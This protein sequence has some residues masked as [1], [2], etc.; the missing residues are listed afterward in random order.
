MDF[1]KITER[2]AAFPQ[3]H[4]TFYD[5]KGEVVSVAYP[6]VCADV[7]RA[8]ERLQG[9][10]IGAGMRVGIMASNCYEWVVYDLALMRLGCTSVAFPDDFG[11]KMGDELIEKYRLALLLISRRDQWAMIGPGK[12]TVY[13]DAENPPETSARLYP[14]TVDDEES[15]L[16]LTF[17]SG[18]SGKIKCLLADQRGAEETIA[19]FYRLFDFKHEDRFLVFLP[20]SSFQQRLMVYAGFYYGFDILL[21]NPPQV[22]TAFKDLK[23]T[24]CLAPPLLYET[25]HA[26]FK[27]TVR[28]LG[29]AKRIVLGSLVPLG[30]AIPLAPLRERLLGICYGKIYAALGGQ[31][32]LMW[33]GMAPI[34]RATLDFFAGMRLPLYE[35]YGLTE[36]GA[37]TTNTREHNRRGSVGRPVV[38]GSVYLAED[39]E[40]MVRLDHLQTTGYLEGDEGE[41]ARTYVAPG[42]IAT[43]DIGR[44]DSEGYLYLVGRK[45]EIIITAQGHKVHPESLEAQ[46]DRC[47]Q[48]EHAVVFGNGLSYLVA[49]IS[50]QEPRTAEAEAQVKRTIEKL[51]ADLPPVGRIRNFVITIE[52]FTRDNGLMTRNLKLDRRAIF[53][54]FEKELLGGHTRP[55]H[56]VEIA[57]NV[58]SQRSPPQ[59]TAAAAR[60]SQTQ[61]EIERTI[62]QTWQEVLL[63]E[64][65][66]VNDNF[67]D[68]GGNSLLMAQIQSRLAQSLKREIPLMEMFNYPTVSSL[69]QFLSQPVA[70]AN[71]QTVQ[72]VKSK[73]VAGLETAEVGEAAEGIAIVGLAG[74]FPG[75]KSI[76]EFWQSLCEGVE[77]ITFFDDEELRAAGVN[78]AVFNHPNYVKAKPVLE[79]MELFDASFFGFNPREAEIMDPQHRVFLE[80]AWEALE[81][82]AYD[83]DSYEGKIGV[84]AG[85]SLSTYVFNALVSLNG[86][87]S[88]GALQQ[89]GIGNGLWSLTTRV[90]YKLNLTGPSVN[91]Q[92]ACS[93]SLSAVHLACQSLLDGQC[94]MALAG[95]VSIIIPNR[96][97]YQ[98]QEGGIFSPDGHC[99]AFDAKAQGTIVG[100]GVGLVVLKRLSEA[101][102]D[103]DY[104]HAVIKGSAMNNDGS[105]KAGFTAPSIEGQAKVIAAAQA[106]AGLAADSIS[107]VEA[108]GTGTSL[109]D[110]IEVQALTK[111]FRQ[112]TER[113]NFCALGSLKPNVGHLDTAA[114]VA[115][116]IKTTLALEHKRLPPSLN[117]EEPNP[118]IDFANSP[119]YVNA[120]LADWPTNGAPLRAG[121]SSFGFGGTN[122]H[123]I[124]EEAPARAAS[125]PG[126]PW[127]LLILSTKM[128]R[129]LAA[130]NDNL[131]DHLQLHPELN[132]AD[133]A[134]SLQV[135]RKAFSERQFIVCRDVP[136]ALQALQSSS[137]RD[138][139]RV[140]TATV[141]EGP[142]R[143]V[144]FMF[145]GQGAQHVNMAAEL[146][147]TEQTFREE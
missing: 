9:W 69:A 122:V 38:E 12:W 62:A 75:A 133:V 100:D 43:G 104:V 23:P 108:H 39:G 26:Q 1:T 14:S 118:H 137:G 95:G 101:I 85:A 57:E 59:A 4:I 102:A 68:L 74:R 11:M 113:K 125:A 76:E 111:A 127:N 18:T 41:E 130:A 92:T 70:L 20:L 117:F 77:S 140:M 94:D 66:G 89:L 44:F 86:L 97:G 99:R 105:L 65:V 24:L 13:L 37:I 7:S 132:L 55:D 106:R 136:D 64:R 123:V 67:F 120:S 141:F 50:I 91:V 109:G 2:L 71:S 144:V 63:S 51:N 138:P 29:P 142:E 98:Y 72:E 90:S 107:Y 143:P 114:G 5:D 28:G 10:G 61:P 27:K 115:S 146:Y 131:R 103:G 3:Q 22:F 25:I 81:H 84:Y 134:Y 139:Q 83:A 80:C 126:R 35:A 49:V 31:M 147:Q 135:G 79:D 17:S 124:V 60:S 145:P 52:Q 53:N 119:F 47:P 56:P 21:V 121:V 112:S 54:R 96:E 93:T 15:A 34:K 87:E 46:I 30:N 58:A 45:K 128:E 6:S 16:S 42:V 19:N 78:P 33:T 73:A 32:R 40:I 82:A 8:V 88:L 116:L 110:P 36:C 48:V 129:S